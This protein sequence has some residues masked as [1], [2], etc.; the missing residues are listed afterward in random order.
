MVKKLSVIIVTYNSE[1][2]I[3]DC[4]S[5]VFK[6]NDIGEALEVI[7]VDN[8]SRD[9]QQMRQSLLELYGERIQIISNKTNGGYGQGN[10]VGIKVS[11]APYFIIMNPDVRLFMPI[12]DATVKCLS[13]NNV[14]MCGFKSM[15][16][17]CEPNRSFY[18]VHTMNALYQVLYGKKLLKDDFDQKRMFLSGACF[19]MNKDFFMKIGMFDENIFMY[20]EE[21]DIHYRLHKMF[22]SC[23]IKYDKAL[24]YIH[25]AKGRKPSDSSLRQMWLSRLYFFKKNNLS[26]RYLYWNE[27]LKIQL[28]RFVV[29]ILHWRIYSDTFRTEY[30]RRV[31]LLNDV[32]GKNI[33]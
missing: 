22:P 7:V 4:L 30:K 1:N 29:M 15:E 14:V 12:F 18:Y 17:C 6:Y 10:N 26:L 32:F 3:F 16:N 23:I 8:N 9:Y 13:Q 11:M 19:A 25:P 5:S 21:N 27:W 33:K 31:C 28:N 2:D 20:G 24:K